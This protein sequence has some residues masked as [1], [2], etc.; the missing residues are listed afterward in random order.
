MLR[1]LPTTALAV[2]LLATTP[3]FAQSKADQARD[4]VRAGLAYA[5]RDK[6][7][8]ALREFEEAYALDAQPLRL[9]DVAQARL[10]TKHFRAAR[11]AFS[12][13]VQSQGLTADQRDR[14]RAGLATANEHISKLRV[15]IENAKPSDTIL[16]DATVAAV[17]KSIEIDP[18][19]H[20]VRLVRDGEPIGE[21]T[22]D[23]GDGADVATTVAPSPERAAE[24]GA[25]PSPAAPAE[26]RSAVPP[27]A[28]V[29]GGIAVVA[30]GA[31]AFFEIR[32]LNRWSELRDDCGKTKT[33][34]PGQ[35]DTARRNMLVGDIAIG[36]AIVAAA[37]AVYVFIV[38]PGEKSE[39]VK[40][41]KPRLFPTPLGLHGVW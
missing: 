37:A 22:V 38:R 11:D 39:V 41:G 24:K 20:V 21:R 25:P 2:A 34:E 10:K 3:A 40:T 33:C 12:Q 13:L 26:K 31:G 4:H 14:A 5:E 32:G 15:T 30:G 1:V 8:D 18:G 16:V 29:F 19:R 36:V 9:Y 6:W 27:L 7:E 35:V 23:V 28:L 17:G